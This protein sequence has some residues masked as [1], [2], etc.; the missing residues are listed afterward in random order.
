MENVCGLK[1]VR[2]PEIRSQEAQAFM[3]KFE[4]NEEQKEKASVVFGKVPVFMS[5]EFYWPDDE[6]RKKN[7]SKIGVILVQ[8]TG[9]VRAGIW[10]RQVCLE[11]GFTLG[12]MM[13]QV[14]WAVQS[15]YP[16]LVMNPNYNIDPSTKKR[17]PFNEN[18][19]KHAVHIWRNYVE[20]SG[21]EKLLVIAHSAGGGC[22]T[23]IITTFPETFFNQVKQ[24]AYT[25]SWVI[26][27]DSLSAAQQAFMQMNAVHYVTSDE[28]LG[29]SIGDDKYSTCPVVSAG[30]T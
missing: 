5:P 8:G 13:P 14:D 16:V 30:H 27:S 28:P 2:V 7:A 6:Q 3:K 19:G 1:E 18:M 26:E 29:V 15:G 24:L 20:P 9:Q 12:S 23:D 11:G 17:V 25:D 4:F 22:V 21:F 10:T